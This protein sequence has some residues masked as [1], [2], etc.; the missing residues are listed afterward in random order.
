MAPELVPDQSMMLVPEPVL[1]LRMSMASEQGPRHYW[2]LALKTDFALGHC[3]SSGRGLRV[4]GKPALWQSLEE[5]GLVLPRC[6]MNAFEHPVPERKLGQ[7]T[8]PELAR[9]KRP[10]QVLEPGLNK[11]PVL[12]H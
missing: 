6:K 11:K 7:T 10:A 9:A 4:K 1:G 12:E 5:P 2:K 8:V 3:R